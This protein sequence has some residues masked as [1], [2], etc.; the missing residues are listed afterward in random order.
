MRDSDINKQ[1]FDR[2]SCSAV[3]GECRRNLLV[4]RRRWWR[5]VHPHRPY[6]CGLQR[7]ERQRWRTL[8]P[9]GQEPGSSRRRPLPM[10]RRKRSSSAR[11][12]CR[13]RG[14]GGSGWQ[15]WRNSWRYPLKVR[16]TGGGSPRPAHHW[17]GA[18]PS[19]M[20]QLW[21]WDRVRHLLSSPTRVGRQQLRLRPEYE[22]DW[23]SPPDLKSN[24]VQMD[25]D[26]TGL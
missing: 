13:R 24:P 26:W 16:H 19:P 9:A 4:Y 11:C 3:V 5:C 1:Q 7:L 10:L 15:T 14:I 8:S 22:M 20:H 12:L 2:R 21:Y 17:R 6:V 25:L 18:D 23:I